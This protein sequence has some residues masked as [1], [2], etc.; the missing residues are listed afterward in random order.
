MAVADD[1]GVGRG[2]L[3]ES[4]Q[5][6]FGLGLLDH[7]DD[8][9]QDDDDHDGDRIHDFAQ[10]QGNHGGH[11]QDDDQKVVELGEKQLEE[12]R[13]GVFPSSS[14]GPYFLSRSWAS[15]GVRPFSR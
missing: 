10:K 1:L 11:D 3:L 8:G 6:R 2:H 15:S 13:D 12:T 5:G 7:P 9:V 14:L 4:R